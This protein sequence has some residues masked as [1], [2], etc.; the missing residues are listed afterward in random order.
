M[1]HD[2]VG[3]C[4]PTNIRTTM[5][6]SIS[7]WRYR[8]N[9][10]IND[11]LWQLD[12]SPTRAATFTTE[13]KREIE[14]AV[15]DAYPFG[16]RAYRPYK[17]WLEECN[18]TLTS[19]GVRAPINKANKAKRKPLIDDP[20]QVRLFSLALLIF[21]LLQPFTQ[22]ETGQSSKLDRRDCFQA[23]VH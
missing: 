14:N 1:P 4:F 9:K 7:P 13:R 18:K 6:R 17:I 5:T 12:V 22:A 10:E 19:I 16:E 8:A 2:E 23:R 11:A 15:K 20:R 21:F 3:R